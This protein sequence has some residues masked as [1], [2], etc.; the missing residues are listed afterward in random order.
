MLLIPRDARQAT[1]ASG[2][3]R[4]IVFADNADTVATAIDLIA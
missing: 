4:I 3:Q 1:Q 2:N